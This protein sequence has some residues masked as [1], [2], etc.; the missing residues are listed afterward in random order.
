MTDSQPSKETGDRPAAEGQ[1]EIK[2]P[3]NYNACWAQGSQVITALAHFYRG[4]VQRSNTW[5]NRLD[6]TFNWAIVTAGAALTFTF[7]APENPHFVILLVL[8]L[9]LVFLGIEARRYR[10]YE[11]WAYRV[12]MMEKDFYASMLTPP[13]APS[14]EWA[15][16]LADSLRDPEHTISRWEALGRRFRRNYVWVFL[17]LGLSWWLKI[18]MHPTNTWSWGEIVQRAAVGPVPG[19]VVIGVGVAFYFGLA[20]MGALTAA[21]RESTSEV[22][23]PPVSLLDRLRPGRKRSG[24][25]ETPAHGAPRRPARQQLVTI[26]TTQGKPIAARLLNE[27]HCGVTG[28]AGQGMYTGQP[29]DV[30]LCVLPPRQ[31]PQLKAIVRQ[32]DPNAF[33]VV[34]PADEV[35]G[36]RF[37]P[38]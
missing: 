30:L 33:V 13:F 3:W 6:T 10:Y 34:N 4:E 5:R 25:G 18:L 28:L 38:L 31:V 22:L 36:R 29:R 21:L 27:L 15:D 7:S 26:I 35:A 8:L 20:L 12:R 14:Q 16:A 1:P 23:A 2:S 19:L 11:L 17:I 37:T 24:A 32:A 9:I